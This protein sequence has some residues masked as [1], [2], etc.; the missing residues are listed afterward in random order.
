MSVIIPFSPR[1]LRPFL[2]YD[3]NILVVGEGGREGGRGGGGREGGRE[4]ER[5]REREREKQVTSVH[6]EFFMR[7]RHMNK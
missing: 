1:A 2:S 3:R 5:E 6:Y 4:G 7:K